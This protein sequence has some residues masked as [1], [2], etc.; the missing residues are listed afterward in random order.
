MFTNR[1]VFRVDRK[2]IVYLRGTIEAY[3]GMAL[4][5]TLDDPTEALIEVHVSP[6]CESLFFDL[7]NHMVTCEG[8]KLTRA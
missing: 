6:G 3:D 5:S 8:I 4:V 2:D 7:I 1:H